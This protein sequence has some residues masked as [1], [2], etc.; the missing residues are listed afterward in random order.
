[1]SYVI[2]TNPIQYEHSVLFPGQILHSQIRFEMGNFS[3]CKYNFCSH[4]HKSSR[5]RSTSI[6]TTISCFF[7]GLIPVKAWGQNKDILCCTYRAVPYYVYHRALIY[8]PFIDMFTSVLI[9]ALSDLYVL[10][11]S[12]IV[13]VFSLLYSLFIVAYTLLLHMLLRILFNYN[14]F[15]GFV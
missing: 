1:M 6:I 4:A 13:F 10:L 2:I 12:V 7:F 14:W 5:W 15:Y 9:T 11:F 8:V 3:C